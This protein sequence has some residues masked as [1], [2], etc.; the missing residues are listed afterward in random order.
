[1]DVVYP[2]LGYHFLVSFPSGVSKDKIDV[3]FQSVSGLS[4]DR[5]T[6]TF[7]EGGQNSFEHVLP[8][9]TSCSNLILK[10]G[11]VHDSGLI[12]WIRANLEGMLITPVDITI[13]L[14]NEEHQPL[15]TW[16]IVHAWPKKWSVSDFN[17]EQGTIAVETLE[18]Q[19]QTITIAKPSPSKSS[20]PNGAP[21][22]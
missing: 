18:M 20:N 3:G 5:K 11:L 1:M 4:V 16:S 13:S 17:A 14:L 9:P 21:S 12:K 6:E 15:V 22:L 2:P 19:Y 10:R 7:R 8:G